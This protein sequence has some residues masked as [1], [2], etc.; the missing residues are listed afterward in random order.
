MGL[1][2]LFAGRVPLLLLLLATTLVLTGCPKG[3][4]GY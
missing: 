3:G 4:G 2:K 1:R